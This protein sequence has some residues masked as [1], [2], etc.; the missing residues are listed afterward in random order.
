M[1]QKLVRFITIDE[2]KTLL[3]KEKD[4]EFK[5][6]YVLGFGSGL[7]ISEVVG[8]SYNGMWT[9]KPLEQSQVNLK[10]H[11][12]RLFGK[13]KKERVTTTSPWLKESNIS[14]LPL[15]INRRTLQD[16]F[17]KLS[18]KI[19]RKRLTFH[20]LRHG[21]ANYMANEKGVPLPM[22]QAMLGHSR[23]D[24]TGIYTKSNPVQA[25]ERA[26]EAF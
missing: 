19:L 9:I 25:I 3:G 18:E 11:Q 13:G 15:N 21:F 2:F 14:L 6:A 17:T 23:L 1:S 5:L 8:L 10:T 20:T 7:R 16:R 4:K 26:W 12:I 24:T 22:V